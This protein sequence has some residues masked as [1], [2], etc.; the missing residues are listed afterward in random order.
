[1]V[2]RLR[3]RLFPARVAVTAGGAETAATAPSIGSSVRF[4]ANI[5]EFLLI[6]RLKA[7]CQPKPSTDILERASHIVFVTCKN[8]F[9]TPDRQTAAR[10][11]PL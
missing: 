2:T 5:A 4:Q 6:T 7:R 8:W 1:M 3:Q 10:C 9:V 11:S